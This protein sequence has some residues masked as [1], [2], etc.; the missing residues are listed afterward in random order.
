MNDLTL[1]RHSLHGECGL[2]L[3]LELCCSCACG[4]SL[5]GECGLKRDWRGCMPRIVLSLPAW[6]VW[7]ET[8]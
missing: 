6:G 4:H 2:K 5:H 8:L 3:E 7:I 1:S